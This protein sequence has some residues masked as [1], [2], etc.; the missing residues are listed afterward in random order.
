MSQMMMDYQGAEPNPYGVR[1]VELSR[2]LHVLCGESGHFPEEYRMIHARTSPKRLRWALKDLISKGTR[3]EQACRCKKTDF[4]PF[5]VVVKV[6]TGESV[7]AHRSVLCGLSE[8]FEAMLSSDFLEAS[9]PEVIVKDLSHDIL[10]FLLHY[11]YGCC[12]A[13]ENR[14]TAN[15]P[16]MRE[17]LAESSPESDQFQCDVDFLFELLACADR[18]L[19]SGLKKQCEQLIMHSLSGEHVT[20][21]YLTAVFYNT[22]RLRIH[23][24][25]FIFLGNLPSSDVYKCVIGLLQSNERDRVIEDFKDIALDSCTPASSS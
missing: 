19:L 12:W 22:P 1:D 23:C 20:V 3:V 2:M 13:L 15:C 4:R 16:V 5:D 11:A 21:A 18:F 17:C 25:Q 14:P 8:V 9:Q 7:E 6:E 10:V 24:L